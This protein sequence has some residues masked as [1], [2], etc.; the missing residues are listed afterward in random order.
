MRDLMADVLEPDWNQAALIA[1]GVMTAE[2]REERTA[3]KVAKTMPSTGAAGAE[4]ADWTKDVYVVV[5]VKTDET[6]KRPATPGLVENPFFHSAEMLCEKYGDP[7]EGERYWLDPKGSKEY[8]SFDEDR[9]QWSLTFEVLDGDKRGDWLF[10]YA[11]PRFYQKKDG[12]WG[13]KLAAIYQAALPGYDLTQ[14]IEDD[15]SDIIGLPLRVSAEPK[16]NPQYVKVNDWLP[17]PK[18]YKP[19]KAEA[20]PGSD[21]LADAD[22]DIPF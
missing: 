4:R 11:S 15:L 19:P 6:E 16:D 14:G 22:D 17:V 5:L 9:N 18:G 20:K 8:A 10:V 12:T 2:E 7:V 3:R 13:G 21:P 1:Q